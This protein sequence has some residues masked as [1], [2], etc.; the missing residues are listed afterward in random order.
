MEFA[1]NVP[2]SPVNFSNN[3]KSLSNQRLTDSTDG[4]VPTGLVLNIRTGILS[5]VP[6]VSGIFNNIKILVIDNNQKRLL[7]NTFSIDIFSVNST[8]ITAVAE[9][10]V[11]AKRIR[12][13]MRVKN[14]D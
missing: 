14:F 7:S 8:T 1:I 4:V 6:T 12:F 3:F 9:N 10:G 5:G 2:I 13:N 11:F